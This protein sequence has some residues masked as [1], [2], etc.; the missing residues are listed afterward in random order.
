MKDTASIIS[1]F[2]KASVR[3]RNSVSLVTTVLAGLSRDFGS[4]PETDKTF[5][6]HQDVQTGFKI[7]QYAVG[8]GG[9][10]F[11][12]EKRGAAWE[13]TSHSSQWRG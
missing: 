13:M 8:T 6:G 10:A 1:A 5:F 7:Q 3:L 4:I 12:A 9:V 2:L 11:Y